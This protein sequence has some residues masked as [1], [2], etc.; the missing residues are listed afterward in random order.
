MI[1]AERRTIVS[2]GT[3]KVLENAPYFLSRTIN[4]RF[5]CDVETDGNNG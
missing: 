3:A 1:H 4:G 5:A 2:A